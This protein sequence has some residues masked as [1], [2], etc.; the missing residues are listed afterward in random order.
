MSKCQNT[1]RMKLGLLDSFMLGIKKS[2]WGL[3]FEKMYIFK[4]Y[5]ADLIF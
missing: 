2:I 4:R 5:K 3:K 1:M